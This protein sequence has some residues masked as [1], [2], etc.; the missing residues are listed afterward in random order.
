MRLA[1]RLKLRRQAV[2]I[3]IRCAISNAYLLLGDKPVLVDTGAPGDLNRILG[4]LKAHKLEPA[5]LSLILLTH[6]HSDHAGC[7]AELKRRSG[8][9]VALHTGDAA[10]ARMGTNG[11]LTPATPLARL[12]RPF[13]DENFEPFQPDFEF[14]DGFDLAPYGVRGKVLA[15]PGHT[16]GSASVV[17]ATGDAI[18]G[19]VLRGSL[20]LPNRART[21]FFC[22]DPDSNRLSIMRLAR[23]GLRRCHPGQFGSFPGSEL[24]RFGSPDSTLIELAQQ[25]ARLST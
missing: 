1:L 11:V 6:A 13:V 20:L 7:A 17:L 19:D 16:P 5:A 9:L 8:A 22:G 18:I 2:I 23:E 21:H 4:T 12:I 24:T 25:P 10:L 15:T 14:R 3:R